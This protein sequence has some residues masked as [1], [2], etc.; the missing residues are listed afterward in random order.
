MACRP[1]RSP[2]RRYRFKGTVG[3]R[4]LP[5]A[6]DHRV[7]SDG[8]TR[9]VVPGLLL[10]FAYGCF[11]VGR[12]G[13]WGD[14]VPGVTVTEIREVLRAWLAG[15]GLRRVAEQAGVDRKTARRYVEAAVAA[16]LARDGGAGQLTDELV[17]QVAQVVR[18]ARARAGVGASGGPPQRDRGAGEAAPDGRQ[19]QRPAG[20]L[21]PRGAIPHLA[22]ST[23]HL[24]RARNARFCMLILNVA[25]TPILS[26]GRA[27]GM[28]MPGLAGKAQQKARSATLRADEDA[29]VVPGGHLQYRRSSGE[30]GSP[31][32]SRP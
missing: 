26:R 25:A 1:Q 20:A 4:R 19:D 27:A 5:R 14:G 7:A 24:S 2:P 29:L 6:W 18:P 12:L 10:A 32:R 8:T 15:A 28:G 22:M 3:H 9:R 31:G 11:Q 23:S 16:G 30:R 13:G 17:G 21:R